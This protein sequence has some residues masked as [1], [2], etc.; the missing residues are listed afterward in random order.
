MAGTMVSGQLNYL[1]KFG[2]SGTDRY[3]TPHTVL[4]G[5]TLGTFA[6]AGLLAYLAPVPVPRERNG[7]DRVMVH[8]GGMIGATAGMAAEATLGIL[9]ASREGYAN[10]GTLAGTHLAIGYLTLAFMTVAVGALVF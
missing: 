4:A 9:T 8:E 5:A 1:D 7:I 6:A 2:G 10:Q 3:K